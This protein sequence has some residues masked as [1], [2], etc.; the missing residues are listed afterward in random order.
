MTAW[1]RERRQTDRPGRGNASEHSPVEY[2]GWSAEPVGDQWMRVLNDG[3]GWYTS[4]LDMRTAANT[5]APVRPL[6]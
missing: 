6:C 5:L 2:A 4:L 1:K 3:E